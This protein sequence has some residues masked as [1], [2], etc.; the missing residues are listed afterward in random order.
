M[1]I[2]R[3]GDLGDAPSVLD[4]LAAATT[5]HGLAAPAALIGE[6]FGSR[7][8]IAPSLTTAAVA[9]GD[10]FDVAPGG[11]ADGPVGGGWFGYL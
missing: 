7:A 2:E 8:V 5:Q 10:V 1:R 4:V 6:W 3:L 11:R 9:P